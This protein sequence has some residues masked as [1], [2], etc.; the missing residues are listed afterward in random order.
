MIADC[1]PDSSTITKTDRSVTAM[2]KLNGLYPRVPHGPMYQE[3]EHASA[4][5]SSKGIWLALNRTLVF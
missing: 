5:D 1:L 3:L 2:H 4:R